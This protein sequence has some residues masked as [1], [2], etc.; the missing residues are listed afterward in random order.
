MKERIYLILLLLTL[1]LGATM[2]VNAQLVP[3]T[4]IPDPQ[5]VKYALQ[6]KT[7]TSANNKELKK[8]IDQILM[9]ENATNQLPIGPVVFSPEVSYQQ[10]SFK[11]ILTKGLTINRGANVKFLASMSIPVGN[12]FRASADIPESLS[13]NY[14]ALEH[15][16]N[17]VKIGARR[18]YRSLY[19]IEDFDAGLYI[20]SNS[21]SNEAHINAH[22]EIHSFSP[23]PNP[24]LEDRS[25]HELALQHNQLVLLSSKNESE[26]C[27]IGGLYAP[28][29]INAKLTVGGTIQATSFLKSSD[30]RLKTNIKSLKSDDL[31][32]IEG[33]KYNL[34]Q[35]DDKS[36]KIG[37]L[38]QDV[39]K[40]FANLVG[41][42]SDCL[43]V[44][45]IEFVPLIIETIKAQSQLI[46]EN[47][48]ILDSLK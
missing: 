15:V 12:E 8:D 9:G 10:A 25:Y 6:N 16:D 46:A 41:G 27:R 43:S 28:S 5:L 11:F 2:N 37:V 17:I 20:I 18:T 31:Y 24:T 39:Q 40:V 34:L 21:Y 47:Q 7:I 14:V 29:N 13:P 1:T 23:L 35:S 30:A 3:I 38:A 19:G 33:V 42:N 4:E 32:K 22:T 36:D 48:K 44:E 45:Y 26:T